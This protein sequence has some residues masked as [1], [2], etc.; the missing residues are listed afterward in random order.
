MGYKSNTSESQ[1]IM[2]LVFLIQF[3]NTGPFL[4]LVN[5]DL[6]NFNIPI[7]QKYFNVGIYTD[8][9]P[10]WYS[11]VGE[12]I[13][14]TMLSNMVF[15]LIEFAIFASIRFIGR[16]WDRRW[17]CRVKT[18]QAAIYEYRELYAGPEYFIHTK[19]SYLLNITFITFMFGAGL[20]MLFPIALGSFIIKYILDRLLLAYS[21]RYPPLYDE[22]LNRTAIKFLL[23]APFMYLTIGFWMFDNVQIFHNL[24]VFRKNY[25][26]HE[27]TGHNIRSFLDVSK[28]LDEP[29]TPL[30]II[31]AVKIV[32]FFT[33]PFWYKSVRRFWLSKTDL[34]TKQFKDG[35]TIAER[36]S[37]IKEISQAP[38]FYDILSEQ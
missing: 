26:Q 24:V 23:F 1:N 30:L 27:P 12:A 2:V 25:N 4:L 19:Y 32:L 28:W 11:D 38:C 14:I 33:R 34:F 35:D 9:G 8:F 3:F 29:S 5:A 36:K 7:I 17:L 18:R 6:S 10:K 21:Y 31:L 22:S 13:T 16:Y 37:I 15:P 20:P